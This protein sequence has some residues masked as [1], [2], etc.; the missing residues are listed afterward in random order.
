MENKCLIRPVAF[1]CSP[2]AG[3]IEF[4]LILAKNITKWAIGNGYA[5]IAVHLFY[6]KILDDDDEK[7][8]QLG[9]DCGLN[10]LKACDYIIIYDSIKLSDGMR[11]EKIFANKHNIP[12]IYVTANQIMSNDYNIPKV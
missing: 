12:I 7:E 9:I 4:N 2:Y 1:I 6:P 10:I 8:R 11:T 3:N 5:P